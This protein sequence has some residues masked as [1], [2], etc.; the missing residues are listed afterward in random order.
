M[1]NAN[2]PISATAI[3]ILVAVLA[4]PR[5]ASAQPPAADSGEQ[6][7]VLVTGAS[8]GI[9]RM[10]AELLAQ[11]GYFV[12]AG[13][14][15]QADLDALDDLD[16]VKAVRLDVTVQGDIDA[17]VDAIRRA[18]RGLYGVVNN[19]GVAVFGP[20]IELAD[21]D[22]EFQFDVNVCGPYRI[23]RAF[24]PLLIES[25]GRVV[26]ISSISGVLSGELF[27]AYSMSKHALEAYTDT[28]ARE[29]SYFDVMVSA[30]EPGN[31]S[32]EIGNNTIA[33]MEAQGYD[34]AESAYAEG[35]GRLLEAFADYDEPTPN[36][37]PP[38]PVAE[39]VLD[40]L[41]SDRPKEHYMVVPNERQA[42]YTIR[43]AIEE[44]VRL[45]EDHEFSF[46]RDEIVAM[47]DEM[48]EAS[49]R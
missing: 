36:S 30:I 17:A 42:R 37:P 24:A 2:G 29:L 41:S 8:S 40:A 31:Y 44:L 26:N 16:N 27:G 49:G 19:A 12:Y 9:G 21:A 32:S 11:S 7:A 20:L 14:R 22:L 48:L 15:K 35:M 13:A 18:G 6:R 43:K 10:T 5:P 46:S 1:R 4:L 47:P 23:T 39:A 34:P 45:N 38:L 3:L 25:K 33:R 28:L